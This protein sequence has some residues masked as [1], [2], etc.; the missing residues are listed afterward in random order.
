MTTAI[1]PRSDHSTRVAVQEELEWTPE[2]ESAGI[3]VTVEDGTVRLSGEVMDHP[4]RLAAKRAALRVEGVS[5]VLDDLVVR[6]EYPVI[7]TE[8]DI[9]RA[10]SRALRWASNVPDT[11]RAETDG[12]TVLL[13]GEVRWDFQRRAATHAVQY[14][15]GVHSVRNL[16][17]LTPRPPFA[18]A[19]EEIKKALVRNAQLDADNIVVTLNGDKAILSGHV[20]SWA[21]KEHAGIVAWSS[22]HVVEVVNDLV[23]RP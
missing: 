19:Q 11:V 3:E 17:T 18:G 6:P 23:V 1:V 5:T 15:H 22:P 21:E 16:I 2:V 4:E 9:R 13:V 7:V 14:L 12:R 10:A 20:R 8:T